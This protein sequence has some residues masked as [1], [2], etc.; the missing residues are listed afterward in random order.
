M[1]HVIAHSHDKNI[2][3]PFCCDTECIRTKI[4]NNI[5]LRISK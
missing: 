1:K 5:V 4:N 2:S 3:K